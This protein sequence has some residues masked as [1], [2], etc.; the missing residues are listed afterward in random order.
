MPGAGSSRG[1]RGRRCPIERDGIDV[2]APSASTP[3]E[4]GSESYP[5]SATTFFLPAPRFC[6]G[7]LDVGAV[8]RS[9]CEL[10]CPAM[11]IDQSCQRAVKTS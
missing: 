7:S 8:P 1:G 11:G 5:L 9:Q 4:K 2:V 10:Q 6:S 3:L